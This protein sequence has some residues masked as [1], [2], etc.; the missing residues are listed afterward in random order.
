MK[1]SMIALLALLLTWNVVQQFTIA[2]MQTALADHAM[3]VRIN[4]QSIKVLGEASE[5]NALSLKA[6]AGSLRQ[7]AHDQYGG[8][9]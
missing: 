6:L 3:A 1:I 8:S 2:E 5:T 4:A 7:V 9:R